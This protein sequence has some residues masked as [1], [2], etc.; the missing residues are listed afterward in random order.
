MWSVCFHSQV[1]PTRAEIPLTILPGPTEQNVVTDREVEKVVNY[2][3][4]Y[5]GLAYLLSLIAFGMLFL[6][7]V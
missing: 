4:L 2:E 7:P 6:T 1:L 3:Q 5:F